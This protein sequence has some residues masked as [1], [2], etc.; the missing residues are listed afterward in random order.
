MKMIIY[1]DTGGNGRSGW[2]RCR[3]YHLACIILIE[4]VVISAIAQRVLRT[5]EGF[6]DEQSDR[7]WICRRRVLQYDGVDR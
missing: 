7:M 4:A 5:V 2:L 6:P 1:L 3:D